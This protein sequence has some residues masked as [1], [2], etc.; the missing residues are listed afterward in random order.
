MR[1]DLKMTHYGDW[2]SADPMALTVKYEEL[3]SQGHAHLREEG[4]APGDISYERFADLRYEGQEY[5]LTIPVPLGLVDPAEV[6][7]R[8]DVAYQAQYGHSSK[9]ARVEVAN[10]RVAALGHLA[11]PGLPDPETRPKGPARSRPVFFDGAE[12]DTAIVD[13]AAL[14]PGETV[15]GPAIIEEETATT[16]VPP[17]WKITVIGGG[18][19]SMVRE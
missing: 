10:L 3:E 8:F 15:R 19:L 14:A 17:G 18:H 13:R 11:R 6:R 2:G 16:L 4:V 7:A 1:H 12:R 9:T 5:V